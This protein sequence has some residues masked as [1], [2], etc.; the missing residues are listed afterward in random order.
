LPRRRIRA[1]T[2]PETAR[3][4][5]WQARGPV[6]DQPPELLALRRGQLSLNPPVKLANLLLGLGGDRP[7]QF[8][9]VFLAFLQGTVNPPPLRRGEIEFVL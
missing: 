7:P 6:L 5:G 3:R 9:D 1:H 2:T 4:L 8:A